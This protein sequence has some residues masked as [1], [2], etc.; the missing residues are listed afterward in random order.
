MQIDYFWCNGCHKS[1]GYPRGQRKL[2]PLSASR[3]K[4]VRI[5]V[6]GTLRPSLY[7]HRRREAQGATGAKLVGNFKLWNLGVYPALVEDLKEHTIVG[8]TFELPNITM[9]DAYEGYIPN[10]KGLYDR[11]EVEIEL[12]DGTKTSAWTYFMHAERF[13]ESERWAEVIESG[14]WQ[15]TLKRGAKA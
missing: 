8:E 7:P 5:F 13:K 10:G 2:C 9:Y 3:E 15:D 4:N 14:D 11:K 12:E 1:H 6:Y